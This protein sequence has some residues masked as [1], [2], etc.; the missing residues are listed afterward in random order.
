M[1]MKSV[2]TFIIGM[3]AIACLASCELKRELFG[4][5]T[6][7]E[8][9]TLELGVN[10]KLPASQT[11]AEGDET[12][13]TVSAD[14]FPLTIQGTGEVSD[15]LYSYDAVTEFA[16]IILPIGTYTVSAHSPG[17]LQKKMTEPYYQGRNGPS[18]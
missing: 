14:N 13:T 3:T 15:Q 8:T 18:R 4:V 1:N 9:G 10:V 7:R 5:Q 11:R 16:P 12:T 17:E 2:N 6:D